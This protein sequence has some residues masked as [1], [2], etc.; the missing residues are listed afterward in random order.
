MSCNFNI[1][2]IKKYFNL[3][4]INKKTLKELPI[5][6]K[7]LYLDVQNELSYVY[8]PQHY[9]PFMYK[10]VNS[11]SEIIYYVNIM[12]NSTNFLD[13]ISYDIRDSVSG[14]VKH[15]VKLLE[16]LESSESSE[17]SRYSK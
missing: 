6:D 3:N 4:L 9:F 15:K 17:L 14:I 8:Y 5:F 16:S 12:N 1:K 11:N 7:I 2:A 13:I 10:N